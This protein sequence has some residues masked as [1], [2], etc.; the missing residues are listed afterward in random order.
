MAPTT[1]TRFSIF[2]ASSRRQIARLERLWK[3]QLFLRLLGLLCAILGLGLAAHCVQQADGAPTAFIGF[4]VVLPVSIVWA[5][6]N[7]AVRL[8]R[9]AP[10]SHRAN[11]AVDL[12]LWIALLPAVALAF[13]L[14]NAAREVVEHAWSRA[15][16]PA[17]ICFAAT[18][19]QGP[20][21]ACYDASL[22]EMATM[23]LAASVFGAVVL[24]THFC[25]F[26]LACVPKRVAAND[27]RHRRGDVEMQ[28][29]S[30]P[31]QHWVGRRTQQHG[32]SGH[33]RRGR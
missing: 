33:E 9:A 29:H 17:D 16:K 30:R 24:I 7:V 23:Q 6:I 11:R 10:L 14:S 4:V 27:H 25:C 13:V 28:Q 18:S 22:R 3:T 26:V 15:G 8:N 32:R 21:D 31:Q 2:N 19:L 5:G 1:P 20:A 12:L